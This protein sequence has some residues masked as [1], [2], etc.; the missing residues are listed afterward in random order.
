M[1]FEF[2]ISCCLSISQNVGKYEDGWQVDA[3]P[4][5]SHRFMAS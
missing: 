5:T 1:V 2:H 4:C 3:I